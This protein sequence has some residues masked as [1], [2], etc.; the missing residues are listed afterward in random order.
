M[1]RLSL[2]K[3]AASIGAAAF[4]LGAATGVASANPDPVMTTCSYTQ[5]INALNATDPANGAKFSS[6]GVASSYLQQFLAAPPG[7]PE[8]QQLL[9]QLPPKYSGVVSRV[10]AVCQNY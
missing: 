9:S 1:M 4:A 2:T 3:I 6:S 5:V 7:S 8:R 10:A